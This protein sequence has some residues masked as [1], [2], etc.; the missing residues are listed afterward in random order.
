MKD[1]NI[2]LG[3][4][5]TPGLGKWKLQKDL[6][7]AFCRVGLLGFGGGPAAIPIFHQE[8]VRNY[9]WMDEDE[10]GDTLA[11]ANTM[12]GP[13][14]TK[15]AGYIGYKVGGKLGCLNAILACVLPTSLMMI[16]LIGILQKYKDISWV[17]NMSASVVPVVAVMLGILSWDFIKKSGDTLG[18]KKALTMLVAA[19]LLMEA[20]NI[21]PAI[22]I[23]VVL[24]FIFFPIRRRGKK[25]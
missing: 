10:F 25:A 5:K 12:P 1:N 17:K 2:P 21:H 16:V 8:V 22:I 7:T 15:L 19:G 6:F 23:V 14:A 24:I 3:G 9:K 20:L 18:W 4:G 11:L 13:I